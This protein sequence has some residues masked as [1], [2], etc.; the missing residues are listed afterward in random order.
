MMRKIIAVVICLL[1]LAVSAVWAV[2]AQPATAYVEGEVLVTFS[3]QSDLPA[4]QQALRNHDLTL[5]KH[6]AWLSEHRHKHMGL[7]RD[8]SRTTAALIAELQRDP[9]VETV[10]PNYL[11]WVDGAPPNDPLFSQQWSLQNAGQT[12]NGTAGTPNDD[13]KFLGAWSLARPSGTGVVVAVI[14]TGVDYTHPDLASNIWVNTGEIP[15]NGIDDDG[16]GLTDDYHGYDFADGTPNPTDSGFHGTHVAGTIAAIGNNFTGVIG[17]DY[18]A[19]V[20][21]LR[22]S[23][24]GTT[25]AS[26]A[27]IEALQYV[28]MMK[29]R[30]VN[31]VA[32][33]ESF[34][35]GGSTAAE[36]AALKAVGDVGIIVCVAAGNNGANNDT[37]P[38][39]PASYRLTNMIVVAAS[40][41]NDALASFSN[42]GP[43]TVD[44]A[45]PGVNILSTLPVSLLPTNSS[46]QQAANT[47][48]ATN[49]VFSGVTAGITATIY[50][51]GLGNT[52][53]FPAGVNGNIALIKRGTLTFAQKVGNAMAA[54]ARTAVIDN[55]TNGNFLGTL[56][57]A[58]NWIP[59][60][61]ISLEDGAT[62]RATPLP[63]TGTVIDS[64]NLTQA[65]QYLNGT[66][67]ATP[68]VVGAVAFAAMNFPADSVTQR[69]HR[70][71]TNVDMIPGLSGKVITGGRLNLLRVVD[72][73]VNGLPDWWELDH[74]GHLGVDPNADPDGDGLS[75]YGEFVAGTDPNSASS[76]LHLTSI[77]RS[78]GGFRVTWSSTPGKTYLVEYSPDLTMPWLTLQSNVPAAG[79]ATTSWLDLTATGQTNRFYRV[80]VLPP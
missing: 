67:M 20:M 66:S 48:V 21:V 71:L 73:N 27:I 70:I 33:N 6:F 72:S 29:G 3:A 31:V 17:V 25:L 61:S 13:I 54:G 1:S 78:G 62:L 39:F 11:R 75:N 68:Q 53:E 9:L 32:V 44:L 16:D 49:L 23:S 59:A 55:N 52:S 15:G 12:V 41:Q 22:A 63:A 4:A 10:E 19:N 45:A 69:I 2:A 18:K 26:S 47:F 8:K 74:F 43:T 28:A 37:T 46:V 36:Q 42:F 64:P 65:Y 14:D 5:T 51:C 79:G 56:G 50:D 35:G 34:G 40:D 7:V 57:S 24:D 38:F 77:G 76:S 58:S 60:V 80:L 30:N